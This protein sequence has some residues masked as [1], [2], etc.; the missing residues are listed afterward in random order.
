MTTS[1][2]VAVIFTTFNPTAQFTETVIAVLADFPVV[3]VDDGSTTSTTV[4]DDVAAAGARLIRQPMNLGIAAA[5]NAGL[6]YA[7]SNGAGYAVTFDQDSAPGAETI[8]ELRRTF[9]RLNSRAN[10]VVVPEQFA[11]VRQAVSNR[12]LPDA[13]RVIQS[14]MMIDAGTYERIGA[15]DEAL[16]IDLVDTE[17]ELRVIASGGRI[18]AAPTKID[19]ELGSMA[20]LRPFGRFPVTIAT[21]VSTPFRYYYRARNRMLLTRK[22]ARTSPGRLLGD[23]LTD[24]AYFTVIVASARPRRA[25]WAVLRDGFRDGLHGSGG[26]IP[27]GTRAQATS[28]TWSTTAE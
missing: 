25:M 26:R 18:V 15:F 24:L 3:V 14:G 9:D 11:G 27:E 5:L 22:Y 16:F 2:D 4:L 1:T 10:L 8:G 23:L 13:R 12:P 19:H 20:R 21:M 6:R 7:F 17:F 28:I